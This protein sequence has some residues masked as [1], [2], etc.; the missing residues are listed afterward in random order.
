[1]IGR[2]FMKR[3]RRNLL[4]V[5]A[6]SISFLMVLSLSS[7]SRGMDRAARGA[8]GSTP[9]DIVIASSGS[10]P[11]IEFAHSKSLELISDTRNVTAAMPVLT[12][13]GR[14]GF[15]ADDWKAA[16]KGTLPSPMKGL[17]GRYVAES[18]GLVGLVPGLA[19]PFVKDGGLVIRSERMG[20]EGFFEEDGSPF[21]D[22]NYTSG[23]T[24]ELMLDENLVRSH[25]LEIGDPVLYISPDGRVL[26]AFR[27]KGLL[28]TSLLGGGLTSQL[29]G[30]VALAHLG[31]LQFLEGYGPRSGGGTGRE[32]LCSAIYVD[33]TDEMS[34][35][36]SRDIFMSGLRERFP[37]HKVVTSE[38]RIYRLEEEVLIL[39]V[40]SFGVGGTALL[41]G[42][43]FLSAIM[44]M[45]VEDRS[46]DLSI[47]RAIGISRTRIYLEVLRDSLV[48]AFLGTLLGA[49]SGDILLD[50]LDSYLKDLYGLNIDFFV[51]DG[52]WVVITALSM[53]LFVAVFSLVPGMRAAMMGPGKEWNGAKGR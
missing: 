27:L 33:L 1:M 29:L 8:S 2:R 30:G 53:V 15:P 25:S 28:K 40:F 14:L 39:T 32:D 26:D 19:R 4:T 13:I 16:L 11:S 18:T 34:A 44:I 46:R 21:H 47:M 20:L 17:D 6:L 52:N 22:S 48:L 3:W 5:L 36:A 35:A 37:G 12:L 31:E 23:W 50:G 42:G 49:L 38:G 10:A 9:R 45:D 41:I 43:L 7:L 24:G 51:M